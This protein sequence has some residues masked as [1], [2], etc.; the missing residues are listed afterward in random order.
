MVTKLDRAIG[1]FDGWINSQSAVLGGERTADQ[2]KQR[3]AWGTEPR[4]YALRASPVLDGD[5]L[6]ERSSA[7]PRFAIHG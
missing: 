1:C 4:I 6:S 3:A 2:V 7:G 5:R